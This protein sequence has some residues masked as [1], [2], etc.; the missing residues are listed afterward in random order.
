[1]ISIRDVQSLEVS[2]N[3]VANAF[4]GDGSGLTGLPHGL[5][6]GFIRA[7]PDDVQ[8]QKSLEI[9]GNVHVSGIV[10]GNA[11]G[12]DNIHAKSVRAGKI[13]PDR[14][15]S[16]DASKITS[17]VFEPH[18]IPPLGADHI[19][20]GV[21]HRDRIPL[22]HAAYVAGG[23]LDPSRIPGMHASKINNGTLDIMRI[24]DIPAGK[25]TAGVISEER[26]PKNVDTMTILHASTPGTLTMANDQLVVHSDSEQRRVMFTTP[27]ETEGIDFWGGETKYASFQRHTIHFNPLSCVKIGKGGLAID[28]PALISGHVTAPEFRGGGAALTDLDA[29]NVTRGALH[30]D[31]V[32]PLDASHVATG[33]FDPARIPK[34]PADRISKEGKLPLSSIPPL[35][36]SLF[37]DGVL[38]EKCIPKIRVDASQV[39]GGTLHPDRIPPLDASCIESGVLH[40]GRIPDLHGSKLIKGTISPDILPNLDA[41]KITSGIVHPSRLPPVDNGVIPMYR[42]PKLHASIIDEGKLH[43]DRIPI[44]NIDGKNITSG[45]INPGRLPPLDASMIHHGVLSV[46]HVPL[47]HTS[48]ISHGRFHPSRLP[49]L[50]ASMIMEGKLEKHILPDLSAA[51]IVKGVFN[52]GRIPDLDASKI[53][54][55]IIRPQCMPHNIGNGVI[56]VSSRDVFVKG[57]VFR[58]N[59]GEDAR[60]VPIQN[61]LDIV[62]KLRGMISTSGETSLTGV[63]E[64]LPG[65]SYTKGGEEEAAV[66]YEAIVPLLVEAIHQL[67]EKI[68]FLWISKVSP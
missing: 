1:M 9:L 63:A 7:G 53:T 34:I 25:I 23:I 32:G 41:S 67:A 38:P 26:I 60:R 42:I 59:G 14:V 49:P 6:S 46:T 50:N 35:N 27:S 3:V 52:I 19:V 33:I 22:L 48:H 36:A 24:P 29:T 40:P 54:H 39:D 8:I 44:I 62:T 4:F 5:S 37:Q 30:A 66:D 65:A 68:G 43:P 15:P 58:E 13:H 11:E 45:T 61:A 20:G 18:R 2:G 21:F 51:D 10:Y 56:S 12:L 16:L 57:R 47:L 64:A 17:G 55:G 28:G 31:R